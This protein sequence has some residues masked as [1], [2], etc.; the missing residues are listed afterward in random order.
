MSLYCS[1]TCVLLPRISNYLWRDEVDPWH[2]GATRHACVTPHLSTFWKVSGEG[3]HSSV[4]FLHMRP[5]IM[6]RKTYMLNW[7]L[8]NINVA[9]LKFMELYIRTF[10][11]GNVHFRSICKT[12]RRF[13]V[14]FFRVLLRDDC[15]LCSPICDKEKWQLLRYIV[16][17]KVQFFDR[18][19]KFVWQ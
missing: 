11:P 19:N 2:V 3:Q 6:K 8:F 5:I 14:R 4:H 9:N 17:R 7:N 18:R 15:I 10:V 12:C 13:R 16:H 1:N